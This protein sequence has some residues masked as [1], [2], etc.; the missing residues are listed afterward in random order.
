MENKQYFLILDSEN[1]ERIIDL[2]DKKNKYVEKQ[3]NYAREKAK[4]PPKRKR[5]I[6]YKP[7]TY[8]TLINV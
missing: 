3:R 4:S 2:I 5:K 7:I 6:T 1:Y 8:K